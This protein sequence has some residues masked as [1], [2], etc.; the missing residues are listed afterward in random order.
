MAESPPR[1]WPVAPRPFAQEAMGSWLGRIA[2]CYRMSVNQ[3]I[4]QHSIE[5]DLE[6][7]NVSWLLLPRQPSQVLDHIAVLARI[8]VESLERLQI[9]LD[10][11]ARHDR[12]PYCDRCL[13]L[14]PLDVTAPYWL[15][16]WLDPATRQCREHDEPMH[17]AP[18]TMLRKCRNFSELLSRVGYR[19]VKEAK[20]RRNR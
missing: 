16:R 15:R 11:A 17:Y 9:P 8:D 12:I 19:R 3:L 2:A 4:V 6:A 20:R 18:I 5:I 7:S 13:V 1:P 14:N 10:W